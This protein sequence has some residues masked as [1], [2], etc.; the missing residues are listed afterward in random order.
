MN[1]NFRVPIKRI[2]DTRETIKRYT[3]FGRYTSEKYLDPVGFQKNRS[4]S[5]KIAESG[6]TEHSVALT[7]YLNAQYY[8]EISIGSPPQVFS[9]VFDTG[10]SNLWIPST[11]CVSSPSC[12]SHRQYNA[13]K[14][15]TY[16]SNGT[17]FSITYSSGS[18][19]G[20]ISQDT[21]IV[22]GIQ[23]DDQGFAESTVE[24]EETFTQA[25][26][27]GIF[28]LGYDT[29]AIKQTVPPFYNMV[30][31]NLVE[32]KLFSFWIRDINDQGNESGGEIVFGG[33]DE[34]RYIGD[35]VWSPVTRKAYWEV[36]LDSVIFDGQ[37]L[38][39]DAHSA[40]IDTGTSLI[41]APVNIANAINSRIGAQ[42]DMYGQ[43]SVNCTLLPSLPEFCFVISATNYC[44]RGED[45]IVKIQ[46]QCI[47]GFVGLDMPSPAG[48][49]WIVGDVF[50][51][52]YY[53]IYDLANDRV[54]F[55]IST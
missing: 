13:E 7:N 49:I 53:T 37:P 22:G 32:Q 45:Y 30:A 51:R 44:L 26:F 38:G 54:G 33:I 15:S 14:S 24:P 39:S 8:G 28:G 5:I 55:A 50:L 43:S 47:S 3:S 41:I 31:R 36:G 17:D 21:L 52:K 42:P 10:S 27:D 2:K 16:I 34:S 48:P 6:T 46:G 9:V 23:I 29:I 20:I 1:L 25:K 35:V 19:K 18:V 4:L 11:R 12:N 40:A